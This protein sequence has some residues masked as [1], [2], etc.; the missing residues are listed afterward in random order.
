[1]KSG[2]EGGKLGKRR[3]RE[4]L[5][6]HARHSC[7]SALNTDYN[8][9]DKKKQEKVKR[10]LIPIPSHTFSRAKGNAKT[11]KCAKEERPSHTR[12]GKFRETC[13]LESTCLTTRWGGEPGDDGLLH[14]FPS[15]VAETPLP[16]GFSKKKT[17]PAY[18]RGEGKKQKICQR[19][20]E[21]VLFYMT[22]LSFN[23][24]ERTAER[25]KKKLGSTVKSLQNLSFS[26]IAGRKRRDCDDG[27]K[28]KEALQG[29]V[30][31]DLMEFLKGGNQVRQPKSRGVLSVEG[32]VDAPVGVFTSSKNRRGRDGES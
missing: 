5:N 7:Q 29:S 2:G 10:R 4:R 16:Q 14:S 8:P 12:G 9:R 3:R 21:N 17:G 19:V 26:A 20:G 31:Y 23:R 15:R 6:F 30:V 28:K 11:S 32:P 18:G 1:L 13:A 24:R 22:I 27:T 25:G